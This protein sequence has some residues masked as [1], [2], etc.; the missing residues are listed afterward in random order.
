[1][2]PPMILAFLTHGTS[3]THVG[4]PEEDP[5]VV[6]V[7]SVSGIVPRIDL[8][9]KKISAIDRSARAGFWI[10]FFQITILLLRKVD[11]DAS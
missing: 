8:L 7:D 10:T 6:I 5:A 3:P 1:M 2:T 11:G 9:S 4:R